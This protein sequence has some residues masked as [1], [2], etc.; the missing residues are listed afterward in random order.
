MVRIIIVFGR[1][2]LAALCGCHTLNVLFVIAVWVLKVM[3]VLLDC[4]CG[5]LP[6]SLLCLTC[7]LLE[8]GTA[9]TTHCSGMH[10]LVAP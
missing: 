7:S 10:S 6:F 2:D 1:F 5:S 8:A 4:I 9:R 3:G